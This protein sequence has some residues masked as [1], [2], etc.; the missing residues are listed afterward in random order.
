[1]TTSIFNFQ[2]TVNKINRWVHPFLSV[3]VFSIP[4]K[5]L[6]VINIL[7]KY[8]HKYNRYDYR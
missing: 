5:N 7:T 2:S 1:M 4:E 3:N 8:I 6:I